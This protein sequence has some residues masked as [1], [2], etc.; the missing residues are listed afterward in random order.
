MQFTVGSPPFFLHRVG[1]TWI[2]NDVKRG[3]GGKISHDG[4][5]CELRIGGSRELNRRAKCSLRL[6][7]IIQCDNDLGK[8]KS[9]SSGTPTRSLSY[10][11]NSSSRYYMFLVDRAD[12]KNGV[13]WRMAIS[14]RPDLER[15]QD[16]A[17]R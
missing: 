9:D 16:F 14:S 4:H 13:G 8:H 1:S 3:V 12:L 10:E 2:D 17:P 5:R 11:S 15:P 7:Q 6:R